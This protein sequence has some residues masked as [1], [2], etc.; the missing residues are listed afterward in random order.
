MKKNKRQIYKIVALIII[1]VMAR[2]YVINP[3]EEKKQLLETEKNKIAQDVEAVEKYKKQSEVLKELEKRKKSKKIFAAKDDVIEIQNTVNNIVDVES[4]ENLTETDEDGVEISNINLKFRGTYEEIFKVA[5][6]L[7]S[8][9][10]SDMIKSI[11]ILKVSQ[12]IIPDIE[13]IKE[14]KVVLPT[15]K[16]EQKDILFECTLNIK[17]R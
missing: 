6:A 1:F 2:V 16:T 5:D 12:N 4:I 17:K 3:I 14:T 11:S 10:L 9:G 15:N 13:E 8:R 7:N